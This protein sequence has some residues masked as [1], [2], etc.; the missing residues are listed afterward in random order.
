MYFRVLIECLEIEE[1]EED[2]MMQNDTIHNSII[3]ICDYDTHSLTAT[4]TVPDDGIAPHYDLLLAAAIDLMPLLKVC[5]SSILSLP[6]MLTMKNEIIYSLLVLGGIQSWR[7]TQ[8]AK[9]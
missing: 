6:S 8:N 5:N 2:K 3:F 1:E 4:S 9:L 7:K